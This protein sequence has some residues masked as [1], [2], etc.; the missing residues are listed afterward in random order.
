MYGSVDGRQ[1]LHKRASFEIWN[2]GARLPAAQLAIS[3][4]GFNFAGGGVCVGLWGGD[5]GDP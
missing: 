1:K 2:F 4:S 5:G 3:Q